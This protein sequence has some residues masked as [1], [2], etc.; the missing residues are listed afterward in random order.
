[1]LSSFLIVSQQVFIL[2]ALMAVGAACNRFRVLG[3]QAVKGIVEVLVLI[4]TP[5]LI[6]HVFQRPFE[7]RLLSGLGWAFGAAVAAHAI[8]AAASLLV[9]TP[10]GARRSVLRYA[11]I[12]SNAGFMGLPLEYALLGEMGVFY[13]AV[14]VVVFNLLCWSY[15]LVVM[16]GSMKD[17]R[18][19]SL[20][21]N[22]GT[23][24]IAAGLPLFI[25]S[26]KTLGRRFFFLSMAATFLFSLSIDLLPLP[27]ISDD[28]LLNSVFGG[29]LLG[30][31]LGLI[32]RGGATTGG[33]D[34]IARMIHRRF[35]FI[36]VGTLLFLIDCAVVLAA[37]FTMNANL[38]LY[39]MICIY[40]SDKAL[41]L[42]VTGMDSSKACFIITSQ[43]DWIKTQILTAM[44]RGVTGWKVIGEYSGTEKRLLMCVVSSRETVTLKRIVKSGDPYAFVFTCDTHEALGE[45]FNEL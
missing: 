36:T 25:L 4:V 9:R 11:V 22:P 17:M 41:D 45:G 8:G 13:G 5:C 35:S 6:V 7:G 31:G 21:V 23:V 14:Y 26:W 33:T 29:V 20:L 37:A 43:P 44:E 2:F 10:D 24:G 28:L 32:L 27:R 39:S 3:E 18:L 42:V 34:M 15:G 38:A 30:L 19:R 16:C 1:M 12:F 40:V